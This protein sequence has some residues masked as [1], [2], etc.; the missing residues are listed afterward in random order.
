MFTIDSKNTILI[1]D[2]DPISIEMLANILKDSYEIKVSTSGKKAIDIVKES[3]PSLILL[4]IQMPE[5]SGFEV[6]KTLKRYREYE[7]IPIIFV[8]SRVDSSDEEMGFKVGGVDYIKKPFVDSIV[9]ARV[10]IQIRL[11]E[12]EELLKDFNQALMSQVEQ[13]INSRMKIEDQKRAQ[14]AILLHQT[15][16]AEL[17][18][19]ISAIAHQWKQPLNTI[20]MLSD[21]V[22]DIIEY[23]EDLDKAIEYCHK[24][25]DQTQF[26]NQTVNDFN[27]FTSPS[28]VKKAFTIRGSVDS[29]IKIMEYQFKISDIKIE[30]KQ[31]EDVSIYGVE[32]EFKQVLLNLFKNS[33]DQF[34]NDQ[35][36][37]KIE[38][39]I[40]QKDGIGYLKFCDNGGGIPE[41]LLPDKL[42]ESYVTTKGDKGTGIGLQISKKIIT[43]HLNGEIKAYN[44]KNWACF[45]IGVPLSTI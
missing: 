28:K 17:G 33:K 44:H 22:V 40:Y 21:G 41:E 9:L 23:D 10:A 29:T 14:E 42:F 3:K 6:C 5:M 39:S 13:E 32:N 8:T 31:S 1:V 2:D 16:L 30:F 35:E 12:Q 27:N 20:S 18:E 45:E 43:E 38:I 36:E 37:K 25:I 15:K 19:M 4:D 34:A 26:M 7:D 24:I 11:Y